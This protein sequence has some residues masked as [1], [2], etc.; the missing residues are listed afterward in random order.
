M[1]YEVNT[2]LRGTTVIRAVDPGTYTITL[3]NMSSNTQL[4]TVSSAS[5]RRVVWS[6]NGYIHIGRGATP[7]PM[8]ALHGA[9]EMRLD[10]MAYSIAN[11][12]TGNVVITIATGGSVVVELSKV[13]TYSTDL[14]R[15]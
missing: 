10:E 4:E 6:S 9:G 7:T 11:T 14:N 3:G 15:L 2:Q 1:A 5:I 13:A 12:N 8:L